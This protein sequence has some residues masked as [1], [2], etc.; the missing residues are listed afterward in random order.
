MLDMGFGIQIDSILK[1]VPKK[2]QTLLFSATIPKEI[3][4]LS[5]KYLTN[6]DLLNIL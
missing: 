4:K 6:P 1:F 2:R 5:T 3:E